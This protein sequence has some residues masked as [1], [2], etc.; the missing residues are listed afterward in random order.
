MP[1]PPH[2]SAGASFTCRFAF[3]SLD[4]FFFQNH[5][6][7]L[8]AH[9]VREGMGSAGRALGTGAERRPPPLPPTVPIGPRRVGGPRAG[10]L[11]PE[12]RAASEPGTQQRFSLRLWLGL[13]L[14]WKGE[15]LI[16]T[17]Q[18]T[19]IHLQGGKANATAKT[20]GEK[21]GKPLSVLLPALSCLGA[22][23][24]S[25][26]RWTVPVGCSAP[27]EHRP[28][29]HLRHQTPPAPLNRRISAPGPLTKSTSYKNPRLSKQ[30]GAARRV[31][32]ARPGPVKTRPV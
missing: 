20:Q 11:C 31:C 18:A 12:H 27:P 28:V 10:W 23:L 21:P 7:L 24:C 3:P 13:N 1:V 14:H 4:P 25:R 19:G 22:W 9:L 15:S 16:V 30:E 17:F 29:R 32:A 26:R 5:I 2:A 8:L 6:R